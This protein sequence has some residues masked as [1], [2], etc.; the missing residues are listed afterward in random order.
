MRPV[1][2]GEAFDSYNN[3]VSKVS[4]KAKSLVGQSTGLQCT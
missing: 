2:D 1:T 3:A 4:A